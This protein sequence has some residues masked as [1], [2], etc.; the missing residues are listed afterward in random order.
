MPRILL[1]LLTI[2]L[3]ACALLTKG[4]ETPLH[5]TYQRYHQT[6]LDGRIVAERHDYFTPALLKEIDLAS[7]RELRA[8]TLNA[9]IDRTLSHYEKITSDR[10][11]LTINGYTREDYPITV[12]IEYESNGQHWLINSAYLNL[13]EKKSFRGFIDHALCPIEAREEIMGWAEKRE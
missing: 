2:P 5:D 1:T 8:L 10:G 11:C 4:Q 6:V 9:D 13:A 3:A 12:F 7:L